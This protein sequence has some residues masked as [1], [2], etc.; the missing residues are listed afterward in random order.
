[1]C[2]VGGGMRDFMYA[3]RQPRDHRWRDA[4]GDVEKLKEL[5]RVKIGRDWTSAV[6]I[7]RSVKVLKSSRAEAICH[8]LINLPQSRPNNKRI[9]LELKI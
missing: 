4:E 9:P 2:S 6:R 7:D 8:N 5:F 3:A 1:M